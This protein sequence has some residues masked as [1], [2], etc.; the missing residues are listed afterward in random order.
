MKQRF[1]SLDV[2]VGAGHPP[3]SFL[4]FRAEKKQVI[5]HELSEALVKLRVAN[6]YDLSSKILLL[7][8]AKPDVKKQLIID[9]GFRCHLT[10]FVR[11]TASAPS[12]FVARLRKFLR[13][14]RC[15]GVRQIGT[16]RIIEI[17]FRDGLYRLYLEFFASGNIILTDAELRII[18]LLRIV[19]EGEGQEPQ[20]VGLTYSLENRQNYGGV[21]PLTMT[22]LKSA[23]RA[24]VDKAAAQPPGKKGKLK[25]GEE[26]RKGLATTVVELPPIVIDHALAVTKF[27]V[28]KKPAEIVENE[29]LLES[30]LQSLEVAR[31]IVEQVTS[32]PACTGYI[33][34]TPRPQGEDNGASAE[35]HGAMFKDGLYEDFHP[36]LPHKYIDNPSFNVL[37]FDGFNKTVDEFFSSL[38][39]RKLASRLDE[40]EAAAKRKL[41]AARQD[42]AQRIGGLQ[43]A[44]TL[45]ARKAG[46]IEAN[47]ERVQEAIDAVNGLI[48]QGMDW[49]HIDKLIEREQARG[50]PVAEIFNLPLRIAENTITV[51]LGEE[52][53]EDSALGMEDDTDEESDAEDEDEDPATADTANPKDGRLTVD[54]DLSLSPWANAREYYDQKRQAAVKAQK[55]EQQAGI[56]LRNAEQKIAVDLKRNLKGEKVVLQPLRRQMWFE[57]FLWF[58]SSDGYLVLGGSDLQQ[59]EILYRRHLRKGDIY[60]HADLHGAASVIIKNNAKTPDTPIPP[61][62]LSQAGNLSVCT[63]SAWDS[64]AG[65]AA[66]WVGADQVSKTA[67]TGEFLPA[68]SFMVRG[69]KSFLP[70]AQLLLGFG[71]MFKIS[72]ESK[73]KHVKHRLYDDEGVTPSQPKTTEGQASNGTGSAKSMAEDGAQEDAAEEEDKVDSDAD[74]AVADQHQQGVEVGAEDEEEDDPAEPRSNPLQDDRVDRSD[75]GSEDEAETASTVPD[76]VAGLRISEKPSSGMCTSTDDAQDEDME[77]G[78]SDHDDE[79]HEHEHKDGKT[80]PEQESGTVTPVGQAH[81]PPSTTTTSQKKG[82]PKRGQRGKAKKMAAKYR[83]QDEEDRALRAALTGAAAG[84]AKREAEAK[85]KA[86]READ[87]AAQTERRQAQRARAQRQAAVQEVIR[88]VMFAEGVEVL[89]EAEEEQATALDALVGTPLPGDEI[90]EA[91][92]VCA[93]WSAMARVKYKAKMQPGAQKKGKAV[94][95][96]WERWKAEAAKKGVLDPAGRDSEKMW[97]REVELI[98]GLRAEEMINAVP[99]S[100]VKVMMGGGSDGRR[101]GG[102]GQQGKGGGKASRGQKK[103]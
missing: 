79:E 11:T 31:Q 28:Q 97:P 67:P 58:I 35:A 86:Q 7:K 10:E 102:G 13:T 92:P 39:G 20:R 94:K 41:E 24:T 62:T 37:S 61:S 12:P 91:V 23:L 74:E 65:M 18:T 71:L 42:Q 4:L 40:R 77:D 55:T 100:K 76:K 54:I 66:W 27:D 26:L 84:Q 50:N 81:A 78:T 46:A 29:S 73:A 48:E 36:F 16:D 34:A 45:N 22:R 90:L 93:P 47:V 101:G 82:Q 60:V 83:D 88:R 56:A 52:E 30:L 44:Q 103:R 19:S 21:P 89:D 1:S 80:A 17:Q 33:F 43:E 72:E 85:A 99:V 32:S 96:V 38:E 95:E 5:A 87:L 25:A 51:L 3:V 69:K 75:E 68:G 2:K 59:N 63:S 9:S 53:L 14:Q 15:T 98:K 64:K 6:I 70:P 49:H 57:K 8:F